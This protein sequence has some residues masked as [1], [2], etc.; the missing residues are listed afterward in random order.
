MQIRS[1]RFSS[2]QSFLISIKFGDKTTKFS[3]IQPRTKSKYGENNKS[4]QFFGHNKLARCRRYRRARLLTTTLKWVTPLQCIFREKRYYVSIRSP[5]LGC[6]YLFTPRNR[7]M[8]TGGVSIN[9]VMI[10]SNFVTPSSTL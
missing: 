7:V 1:Q 4:H 3:Q 10:F 2:L 6:Q 9:H 8:S 5:G